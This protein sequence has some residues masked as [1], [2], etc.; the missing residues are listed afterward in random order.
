MVIL[1]NVED[2]IH[3]YG[4]I[5]NADNKERLLSISQDKGLGSFPVSC[6]DEVVTVLNIQ[7]EYAYC[8]G[9][10]PYGICEFNDDLHML[11]DS[12]APRWR[13]T[14]I[15]YK[16]NI[17]S[18]AE[19]FY[20]LFLNLELIGFSVSRFPQEFHSV[21]TMFFPYP[22]SYFSL[23][24]WENESEYNAIKIKKVISESPILTRDT[25]I[26]DYS[27]KRLSDVFVQYGIN[28]N[29]FH[30]QSATFV[31]K[32]RRHIAV[33]NNKGYVYGVSFN[34]SQTGSNLFCQIELEHWSQLVP[35]RAQNVV[36][37]CYDCSD[38]QCSH[39]KLIE[40][41]CQYLVKNDIRYNN[42]QLQK[43]V[44]LKNIAA[45]KKK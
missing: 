31:K 10:Y 17:L 9:Y 19:K 40:S 24:R 29:D 16:L 2:C 12:N 42:D 27:S 11:T 25:V 30:R 21:E 20:Q 38:Q 14:E 8:L 6:N 43:N 39:M 32:K 7:N 5:L 1:Q 33:D 13:F 4:L 23:L 34:I 45:L 44:W 15:E 18:D 35:Q 37:N 36:N 22:D 3:R 41:M 26:V 28:S